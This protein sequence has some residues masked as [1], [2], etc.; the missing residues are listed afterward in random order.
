MPFV[1]QIK[2]VIKAASNSKTLCVRGYSPSPWVNCN[3]PETSPLGSAEKAYSNL[4]DLQPLK[5]MWLYY[6][7]LLYIVTIHSGHFSENT[8]VNIIDKDKNQTVPSI[9]MRNIGDIF[10]WKKISIISTQ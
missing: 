10:L 2:E 1:Q 5:G 8:Y 6:I 4:K 3:P 9:F 7:P